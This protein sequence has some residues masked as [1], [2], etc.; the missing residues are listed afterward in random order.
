MC[1]SWDKFLT[2]AIKRLN[3]TEEYTIDEPTKNPIFVKILL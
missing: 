3:G 1:T 2:L